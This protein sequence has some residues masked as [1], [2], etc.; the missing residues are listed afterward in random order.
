M[1]PSRS[2]TAILSPKPAER[3]FLLRAYG[4][5]HQS[6]NRQQEKEEGAAPEQDPEEYAGSWL[7]WHREEFSVSPGKW[8]FAKCSSPR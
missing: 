8:L 1:T 4:K 7:F 3:L 6:E 5:V 2:T